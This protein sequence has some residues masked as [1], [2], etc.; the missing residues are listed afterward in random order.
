PPTTTT[1]VAGLGPLDPL[2]YR[3][4]HHGLALS[5]G[6][7]MRVW[8]GLVGGRPRASRAD[9]DAVRARFQDLLAADLANVAAGAYPRELLFSFRARAYLAR[10]PAAL[11]EGTRVLRR[12]RRRHHDDLPRALDRSRYPHYY[13]RNFHWQTDGWFSERSARVYDGNV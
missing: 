7:A 3:A 5:L 12:K 2:R 4:A 1:R 8:H 11:I 10:L 9:L 6:A 13:L